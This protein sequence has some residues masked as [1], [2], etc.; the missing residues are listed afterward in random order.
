MKD[1]IVT[2]GL[3]GNLYLEKFTKQ[4]ELTNDNGKTFTL[5][6]DVVVA[7]EAAR[8]LHYYKPTMDQ[9]GVSRFRLSTLEAVP[10]SAKIV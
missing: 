1:V 10:E 5:I 6:K 2:Q 4:N 8:V 9:Y 3:D 7:D